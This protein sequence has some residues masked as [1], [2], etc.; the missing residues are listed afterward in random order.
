M[1]LG[2]KK[3]ALGGASLLQAMAQEGEISSEMA[4]P[5]AGALCIYTF[6]RLFTISKGVYVSVYL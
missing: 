6:F 5:V 3:G 1:Q 2:A 4:P